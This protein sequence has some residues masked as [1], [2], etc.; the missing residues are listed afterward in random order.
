MTVNFSL[1]P[2]ST[3]HHLYDTISSIG[4][5]TRPNSLVICALCQ[6]FRLLPIKRVLNR[7]L[8]W[9]NRGL[10]KGPFLVL[11]SL[12]GGKQGPP[13]SRACDVGFIPLCACAS[14]AK[15]LPVSWEKDAEIA[16]WSGLETNNN[17]AEVS[18]L[19]LLM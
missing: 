4:E 13:V 2:F 9:K 15:V 7:L 11:A 14:L 10:G 3:H 17:V 12:L 8:C 18:I 1:I 6:T 16:K 19:S 5:L